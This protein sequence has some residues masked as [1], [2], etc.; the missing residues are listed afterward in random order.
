VSA[1]FRRILV[2][3]DG[4]ETADRALEVAAE[5]AEAVNATLTLIA[6]SPDVPGYAYRAGVDVAALEH[7]A[8]SETDRILRD[9]VAK[10]PDGLPVTTVLKHG[11]PGARIVEQI[12]AGDHDLL[13]MGSRGRGRLTTNLFGSVGAYVHYHARVA[14]LVIHPD[15]GP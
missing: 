2:A 3:I 10:L 13:A 12:E 8:E 6:V 9:A 1:I 5:L 14:M 7:E 15:R 11:N 4:S